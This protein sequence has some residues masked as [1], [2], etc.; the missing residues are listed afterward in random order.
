M[1]KI[2]ALFTAVIA[3]TAMT[4]PAFAL[5]KNSV[6]DA[7]PQGIAS[8]VQNKVSTS[9]QKYVLVQE[10]N[11][12]LRASGDYCAASDVTD[13]FD[14]GNE[15]VTADGYTDVRNSSG[16]Q[17]RHYTTTRWE[18]GGVVLASSKRVWGT[19][20]IHAYATVSLETWNDNPLIYPA[21]YW[22]T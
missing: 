5:D 9:G 1:K 21:V 20:E 16:T 7:Q 3:F 8:D 15:T 18:N 13:S 17:I 19:G 6:K 22:G 2:I 11:P 12:K 4:T 14:Y 10:G